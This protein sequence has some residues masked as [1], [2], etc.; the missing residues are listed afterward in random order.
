MRNCK[1]RLYPTEE[2][3]ARLVET[4]DGCH[5]VYNY[6]N[7]GKMSEFDMNYALV[8]LKEQHPWLRNYH[9][10]MLQMVAKQVASARNALEV[11][12]AHGHRTGKLRYREHDDYNSFTY[13]Q[14]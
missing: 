4:L 13:N 14:S 12:K 5:W 8:E 2:Q 9:S 6:F 3:E 7:K 10:K 11:L 1:F